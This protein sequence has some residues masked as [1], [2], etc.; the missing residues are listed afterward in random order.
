MRHRTRTLAVGLAWILTTLV[1]VA[2]ADAGQVTRRGYRAPSGSSAQPAGGAPTRAPQR[3]TR[4]TRATRAPGVSGARPGVSGQIRGRVDG[5]VGGRSGGRRGGRVGLVPP[6]RSWGRGPSFSAGFGVSGRYGGFRP[7]RY[8][9]RY[10]PYGYASAYV[11]PYRAYAYRPYRY[12]GYAYGVGYGSFAVARDYLGGVRLQVSPRHAE[13]FVGGHYVGL[14][15]DFDGTFQRLKLE[16]G[17]Y[18]IVIE[19]PG[20]V[21][22]AL[23]VRV[24][25]GQTVKYRGRLRPIP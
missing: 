4:P 15:D 20:Y 25:A 1:P 5:R 21:P 19:A 6:G 10:R 17:V 18:E 3:A 13:V 8:S 24:L 22:L 2:V 16:D 23:D 14:V 7:P 11:Y 12:P 9:G